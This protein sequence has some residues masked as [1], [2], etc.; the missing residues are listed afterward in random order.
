M[1]VRRSRNPEATVN[2]PLVPESLN[3]NSFVDSGRR[4]VAMHGDLDL[5]TAAQAN[6]M[7]R[8]GFDVLDVSELGWGSASG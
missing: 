2:L 5:V 1:R 3:C 4:V 7:L 6:D 8:G